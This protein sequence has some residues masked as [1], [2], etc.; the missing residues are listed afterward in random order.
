VLLRRLPGLVRD[1]VIFGCCYLIS[2]KGFLESVQKHRMQKW[3]KESHIITQSHKTSNYYICTAITVLA[4][5][6]ALQT[7]LRFWWYVLLYYLPS[8]MF[9]GWPQITIQT[10]PRPYWKSGWLSCRNS[11]IMWSGDQWS[12]PRKCKYPNV[13]SLTDSCDR[14]AIFTVITSA[15]M[16]V[17][18]E[19]QK[20]T[21]HS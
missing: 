15:G 7:D 21:A 4:A 13:L 14:R 17:G 2:S 5:T 10:T 3:N 20:A 18:R 16:F 11:T 9:P 19:R 12:S 8:L 6:W 1:I